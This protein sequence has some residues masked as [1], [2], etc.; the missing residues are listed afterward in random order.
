MK[1]EYWAAKVMK[2]LYLGDLN[3]NNDKEYYESTASNEVSYVS[4]S[5]RLYEEYIA[6][7]WDMN[8]LI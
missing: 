3:V 6:I 1:N 8:L 5:L 4:K 7:T 2:L